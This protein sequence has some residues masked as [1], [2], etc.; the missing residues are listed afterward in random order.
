VDDGE[1]CDGGAVGNACCDRRT[2]KLRP[3]AVCDDARDACCQNCRIKEQ[4]GVCRGATSLCDKEEKC[5]GVNAQC[6]DDLFHEPG[7]TCQDNLGDFGACWELF[8]E[9][10]CVNRQ[11]ICEPS[12]YAG[13]VS[14]TQSCAREVSRVVP[15]AKA[16]LQSSLSEDSCIYLY[17]FSSNLTCAAQPI[18]RLWT[19]QFAGFP[20]SPPVEGVYPR[21]CDGNGACRPLREMIS[22]GPTGIRDGAFIAPT[23]MAPT[24]RRPTVRGQTWAPSKNPTTTG[25][26][27]AISDATDPS[28]VAY[29]DNTQSCLLNENDLFTTWGAPYYVRGTDNSLATLVMNG[30]RYVCVCSRIC[31]HVFACSCARLCL[32][33][34]VCH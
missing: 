10:T 28:D 11:A 31:V 26:T 5:D 33:T 4:G 19:T 2:C 30:I 17:C 34:S 25:A 6:P 21:L 20:C 8:G 18:V 1:E 14:T 12:G 29:N 23:S 22:T 32:R 24:T 13:G 3:R 15:Q 9:Y 27:I 16:L 7:S